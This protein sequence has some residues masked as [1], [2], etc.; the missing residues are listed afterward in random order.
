GV[1]HAPL[2]GT[3]SLVPVTSVFGYAAQQPRRYTDPLGLV[4]FAFDGTR[5]DLSTA[6]NVYQ[7]ALLYRNAEDVR[8]GQPDIYYQPG[9]GDPGRPD[10]DAATASSADMIVSAQC[11]RLLQHLAEFQSPGKSVNIDL[12]GYSRGA[13]LARHFANQLVQNTR[14][15][16]FWQ[17]DAQRGTV[18]ACVDLRFMGLF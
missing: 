13:S 1:L 3:Q 4:L 15:G 2:G 5:E 16:R 17:H 7:M 10:L 6:T 14:N 9:P 8:A 12:V 18:T 11:G